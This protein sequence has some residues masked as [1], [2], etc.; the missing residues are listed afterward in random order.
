MNVDCTEFLQK[1]KLIEIFESDNT[2][3]QERL[4]DCIAAAY[5]EFCFKRVPIYSTSV[6]SAVMLAAAEDIFQQSISELQTGVLEGKW[7]FE[8]G[9]PV[10]LLY[11]IF[12]NAYL[13]R[14]ATEKLMI[15]YNQAQNEIKYAEKNDKA[16][17]VKKYKLEYSYKTAYILKAVGQPCKDYLIWHYVDEMSIQ[18][19][20]IIAGKSPK[21]IKTQLHRC[22]EYFKD[23]SNSTNPII[24]R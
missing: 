6:S 2:V 10:T 11:K 8:S 3:M 14:L 4:R 22:R 16:D 13:N 15:A 23:I 5:K 20:G 24:E 1:E 21:G 17:L 18:E 19:I 12:K 7:N 9:Q